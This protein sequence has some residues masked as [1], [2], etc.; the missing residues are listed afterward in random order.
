[1]YIFWW[2]FGRNECYYTDRS[3]AWCHIITV[4]CT[5]FGR[6]SVKKI[7]F[8]YFWLKQFLS[9]HILLSTEECL[10]YIHRENQ[11]VKVLCYPIPTIWNPSRQT[12]LKGTQSEEASLA[13]HINRNRVKKI[14]TQQGIFWLV[15][16]TQFLVLFVK[17]HC[18]KAV[19]TWPWVLPFSAKQSVSVTS[20]ARL[21]HVAKVSNMP[22][23]HLFLL[24]NGKDRTNITTPWGAQIW[25]EKVIPWDQ[26]W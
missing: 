18:L 21:A 25:S 3:S 1:M 22:Q 9:S 7:F 10:A 20:K 14:N 4:F 16:F 17:N 6:S 26:H 23:A 13:R 19:K 24:F 11:A 2:N 12:N 8:K 15:F 5:E